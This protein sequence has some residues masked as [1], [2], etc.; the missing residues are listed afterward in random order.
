MSAGCP[1]SHAA[2][3]HVWMSQQP[4]KFVLSKGLRFTFFLIVAGFAFVMMGFGYHYILKSPSRPLVLE[5]H[6]EARLPKWPL[7]LEGFVRGK[8]GFICAMLLVAAISGVVHV[9]PSASAKGRPC[10]P[11]QDPSPYRRE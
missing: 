3:R 5:R 11:S 4:V 6:P 10:G 1:C 8:G 7:R 2:H 9:S